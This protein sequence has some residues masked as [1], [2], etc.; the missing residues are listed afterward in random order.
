MTKFRLF[1][2]AG[3][4][5]AATVHATLIYEPFTNDPALDGWQAYG[6][7]N[8]FQWNA[9]NQ[10]LEVTWDST[11][12]NSYYYLP[13]D[14]TYTKADGFCLQF[15]LNLADSVAVGYFELAVGLCNFSEASSTNF[16]RA[17][18]VSPDLCEFDY[19][20]IG[21][22]SYGPSIDATLVDSN[23]NFYFCYDDTQPLN[24]DVT[25][26][27]VLIHPAGAPTISATV[28][29]NGV[30]MTT[31]PKVY[32][33]GADDFQLDTM[34]VLNYTTTDDPYGD[35]LLAHGSVGNLAFASPLPVGQ[36]QTTGPAQVQFLSDT[37]WVYTL[38]E[39]TNFQSWTAAAIV[40]PGNGTN[41]VLQATNPVAGAAFY[42]VRADLP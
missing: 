3:L 36:A 20:P 30:P 14:R 6:D 18:G 19:F 13:L 40:M 34:A 8:L 17:N 26:H 28:F 12:V 22:A 38:E 11:Q 2:V 9:T 42:R 23:D 7:T 15:D 32:P 35:L 37:N 4:L 25:Y 21:M 10:V 16:S 29:T 24:N 27:V 31:L 39:T 1:L 41:L 33:G 5:A